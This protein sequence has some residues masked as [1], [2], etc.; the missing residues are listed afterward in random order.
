MC[1]VLGYMVNFSVNYK[2]V[3]ISFEFKFQN[4]VFYLIYLLMDLIMIKYMNVILLSHRDFLI[5][6]AF[7]KRKKA[8]I[9]SI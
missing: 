6:F 7:Q 3:K 5:S 2:L 8:K 4:H 9:N 1:E